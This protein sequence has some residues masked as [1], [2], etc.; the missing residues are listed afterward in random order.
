MKYG[1]DDDL[2]QLIENLKKK[3]DIF[4]GHYI[5]KK[6]PVYSK[7]SNGDKYRIIEGSINCGIKLY[8]KLMLKYGKLTPYQ[9]VKK[10]GINI[11][12]D[13]Q[14]MDLD[15][16]FT[17]S[18]YN[19]KQSVIKISS[20]AIRMLSGFIEETNLKMNKNVEEIAIAHELFHYLEDKEDN[21][22]TKKKTINIT[23]FNIFTHQICPMS[24]SEIGAVVV[25]KMLMN[26]EYSPCLYEIIL[27]YLKDKHNFF[28]II[29]HLKKVY[30]SL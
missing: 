14:K 10:L 1:N 11:V 12:E 17:I 22:F 30:Y 19:S 28:Q 6:D 20:P 18:S 13:D 25:S 7:F 3:D 26:L 15:N 23:V 8:Q 21:I 27:L 2:E 29:N 9:Y 24:A 16:I 5:L 4:W